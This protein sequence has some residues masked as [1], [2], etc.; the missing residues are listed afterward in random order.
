[1]LNLINIGMIHVNI[2]MREKATSF[3]RFRTPSTRCGYICEYIVFWDQIVVQNMKVR[4]VGRGGHFG[5]Y[6]W[7]PEIPQLHDL[8]LNL[9]IIPLI[10]A[11]VEMN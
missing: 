6:L 5:R 9:K 4:Q 8:Y 2:P 3:N 10:E 11:P 1:M 7:V